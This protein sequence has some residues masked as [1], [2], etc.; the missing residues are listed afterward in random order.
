MRALLRPVHGEADRLAVGEV[1]APVPGRGQ[2]P[3]RVAAASV[4]A[5]DGP[6]RP[7]HGLRC[8]ARRRLGPD[9]AGVVAD[10]GPGVTRRPVGDAVFV[11]GVDTGHARLRFPTVTTETV[12]EPG[13]LLADGRLRPLVDAAGPPE[14]APEAPARAGTCRARGEVIVTASPG[15]GARHDHDRTDGPAQEGTS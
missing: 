3:V 1:S 13:R 14:H 2:V 10:A 4:T 9:L 11:H 15:V 8:P 6:V 5:A 12:T 7:G